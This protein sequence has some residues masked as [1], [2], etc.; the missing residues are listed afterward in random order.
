MADAL[1]H[2]PPV[3]VI[4]SILVVWPFIDDFAPLLDLYQDDETLSK[5][6]IDCQKGQGVV[7][8]YTLQD[9]FLFRGP[10]LCVPSSP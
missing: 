7:R 3:F 10:Q 8:M 5:P 2:V 4:T 6:I 1:S 9:G